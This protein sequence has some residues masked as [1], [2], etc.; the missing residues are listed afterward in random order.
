LHKLRCAFHHFSFRAALS[1]RAFT[2]YFSIAIS[3]HRRHKNN[4]RCIPRKAITRE[5]A[6][7]RASVPLEN[8][9]AL[10]TKAS[11]FSIRPRQPRLYAR[12]HKIT[13]II[14][15]RAAVCWKLSD[16]PE[17]HPD[18]P[19]AF[20]YIYFGTEKENPAGGERESRGES[21]SGGA[22]SPLR[23]HPLNQ[24]ETNSD[25]RA[26]KISLTA[27]DRPKQTPAAAGSPFC[28]LT[29]NSGGRT[30]LH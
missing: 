25:A 16:G 29:I 23:V 5:W 28:T 12:S 19:D 15:Q 9:A 24:F 8:R 1:Q 21:S 18:P 26:H 30:L 22:S 3:T 14:P 13:I 6:L 11:L 17:T 4:V 7:R 27:V 10:T 2:P 20:W